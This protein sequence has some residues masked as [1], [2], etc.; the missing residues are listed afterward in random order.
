MK[1]FQFSEEKG[2]LNEEIEKIVGRFF[3]TQRPKL[4]AWMENLMKQRRFHG[5]EYENNF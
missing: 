1:V 4:E 5:K 3:K 2:S